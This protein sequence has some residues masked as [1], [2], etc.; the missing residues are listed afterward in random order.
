MMILA[1]CVFK[2]DNRKP[3]LKYNVAATHIRPNCSLANIRSDFVRFLEIFDFSLLLEPLFLRNKTRHKIT[4]IR[5]GL[6]SGEKIL[7]ALT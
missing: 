4:Q 6:T 5:S 2:S 1:K 7:T 3:I